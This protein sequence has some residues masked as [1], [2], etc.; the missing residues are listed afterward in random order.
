MSITRTVLKVFSA[1]LLLF[2]AQTSKAQLVVIPHDTT[3]CG[4]QLTITAQLNS[5]TGTQQFLS[6]DAYTGVINIGFTFNY[7]GNNYTQL[8]IGSNAV[9]NFNLTNAG[10]YCTWPINGAIPGNANMVNAIMGPWMDVNPGTGGGI[11]YA[12]TG[13][14]PNRKFIATWCGVPYFS[15]S[16]RL[17]TTQIIL[18]ETTNFIEI[19]L[20]ERTTGCTWN[21]DY[22][23]EGVQNANATLATPVP[24]RNFPQIWGAI[25]SAHRFEYVAG[26][27]IVNP[28]PYLPVPINNAGNIQW[29]NGPITNGNLVGTGSSI[30]VSPTVPTTYY[31]MVTQC[32][33]TIFDT[34][35]VEIGVGD[36]IDYTTY[37]EPSYCGFLDGSIQLHG[38]SPGDT[39]IV[40]YTNNGNP[41]PPFQVIIPL[42]STVNVPNLGAG[43]YTLWAVN[44]G[45]ATPPVNVVLT[46]P[47]F[48]L[49][50]VTAVNP[51]ICGANDGYIKFWNADLPN[52]GYIVNYNKDGVPQ[53]PANVNSDAS[54][55]AVLS[56]LGPG[57][58]DNIV[59]ENMFGCQ[60]GPFGPFTF[61][62]PPFS[63]D[64]DTTVRFSCVADTVN[65]FDLSVG[66]TQYAWDFGDGTTSNLASPSHV[67]MTQGVFT[68]TLTGTNGFCTD[69]KSVTIPLVHPL[70]AEFT[71]SKDS[72][73]NGE[74]IVFTNNS[75]GTAGYRYAW[76]FG[77]G[78]TDTAF[79]TSHTYTT[80]GIFDAKLTI[81]DFVPCTNVEIRPIVVA[82]LDIEIGPKDTSVCLTD[83]MVLY[84]TTFAPP[85]FSGG[86]SYTWSPTADLTSS[87]NGPETQFFTEVPGTYQF[88]LNAVGYPMGCA[89]SDTLTLFVQPKPVL[90]NVTPNTMIKY[91]ETIQLN[92]EGVLYY[93]W[94]PP[95]TL[96]NPN[97]SNPIGRPTEPV[98]YTVIGMNEHGGCRDT[99]NVQVDIDYTMN[100]FIPSVFSPNGDGKNDLFRAV[101]LKY[102]RVVEFRV[103]NRWGKEVYSAQDMN[104]G[105]DGT[106]NGAPQDP[107]VYTYIIRVTVPDGDIR[108]YKG[109]VTLI[110]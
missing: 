47:P 55:H 73:C 32:A 11:N 103:F 35:H 70:D 108:T 74:T 36:S 4:Q 39:F 86:I 13:V 100:E 102:Q 37:V 42:D 69:S 43:N 107:G 82:S 45:C 19:H 105:W 29:F 15:C 46:D 60:T 88:I 71:V 2:A 78:T 99:A 31:A 44:N 76:D 1:A 52:T 91:G 61:V 26:A 5:P 30:T 63:V 9:L 77:D 23:I 38:L 66:V 97:I 80:D 51:T 41:F 16:N 92:A 98:V 109:N 62:E 20:G 110:R 40:N 83:P 12:T 48:D 58:Y 14:A 65:F 22:A 89:A 85:Y 106:Y 21:G 25:N 34:C 64:F 17:L 104:R 84:S 50:S 54:R 49:D 67:F 28:I 3:I 27:Y 68:V 18:Y 33:D 6:D 75:I 93:I 94:T 7:Y 79:N 101:N 59:F 90:V 87:P 56:N 8:V 10:G 24:G 53:P 95:A 81:V 57:T 72:I 96:D